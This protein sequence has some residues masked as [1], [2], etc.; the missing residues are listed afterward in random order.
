M[1]TKKEWGNATWY[2]FHTLSFKMKDEYF[3]VLKDEFLNICMKICANLPCPD[4]SEHATSI[5]KNLKRDSIKTKKDLQ[6]FFFDFHNAVNRRIKKPL[7]DESQMFMYHKAITN[8]IVFNYI[9]ILSRK[10]HNIK[11]ISNSFHR[12]MAMN[13]FKKWI[14]HNNFKFNS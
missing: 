11:L 7:F 1:A 8:N 2:L 4:C 3:E 6:L 9:T 12:D 5:M 13:D 14:S 10:Q